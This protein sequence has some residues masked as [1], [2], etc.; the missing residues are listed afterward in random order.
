MSQTNQAFPAPVCGLKGHGTVYSQISS[1]YGLELL[2]C[3]Y[4]VGSCSLFSSPPERAMDSVYERPAKRVCSE[5]IAAFESGS[6]RP[7][8]YGNQGQDI[9]YNIQH[10]LLNH[11]R[12]LLVERPPSSLPFQ[13]DGRPSCPQKDSS[14]AIRA[15]IVDS[16]AVC[17]QESD[18]FADLVCFGSVSMLPCH[19]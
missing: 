11:E 1:Q 17:S 5:Q 16:H 4:I 10:F 3:C 7:I 6:I 18:C 19:L 12:R 15:S 13:P 14:E 9:G 8:H 2:H